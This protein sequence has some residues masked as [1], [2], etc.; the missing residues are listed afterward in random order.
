MAKYR[1]EMIAGE[2]FKVLKCHIAKYNTYT[3]TAGLFIF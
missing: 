2:S 3:I 1:S